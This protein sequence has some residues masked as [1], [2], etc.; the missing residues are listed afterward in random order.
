MVGVST[1]CNEIRWWNTCTIDSTSIICRF[2]LPRYEDV[3][4]I[5]IGKVY[6]TPNFG[7]NFI[8]S[9]A[10]IFMSLEKLKTGVEYLSDSY[11]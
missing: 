1:M 5:T 6:I 9:L 2:R 4:L 11:Q 3:L 7:N 8:Y 10:S